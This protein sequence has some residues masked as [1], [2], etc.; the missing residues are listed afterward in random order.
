MHARRNLRRIVALGVLASAL[1]LGLS[2]AASA[3]DR[4]DGGS[5]RGDLRFQRH[6]AANRHGFLRHGGGI[7]SRGFGGRHG[8]GFLES[9]GAIT[10]P[11]VLILPLH[12]YRDRHHS[13]P[14]L[15]DGGS[16]TTVYDAPA[17]VPGERRHWPRPDR[18]PDGITIRGDQGRGGGG[19]IYAE[20]S[21]LR[22]YADLEAPGPKIIDVAAARLDRRPIRADGIDVVNIGGAKLIRIGAG[23]RQASATAGERTASGRISESREPWTSGWLA[24]CSR[25]HGNFDPDYGTFEGRDGERHFCVAE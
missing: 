8:H 25:A 20:P 21:A 23:Y 18:D 22:D 1:V 17:F 4:H 15:D 6:D 11:E 19:A 7:R 10:T 3:R 13:R 2:P 16:I 14:F 12:V 24:F 9:G 5:F